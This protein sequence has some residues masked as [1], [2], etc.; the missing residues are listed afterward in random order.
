MKIILLRHEKRE[1]RRGFHSHLTRNGYD[2]SKLLPQKLEKYNIDYIFSSPFIRTLQTVYFVSKN[3]GIKVNPEYGLYEYLS[4]INF[5]VT[6]WYHELKEL[7]K[8]EFDSFLLDI[9]NKKYKSVCDKNDLSVLENHE[10]LEKRLSKFL[11]S[12]FNNKK[13]YNKTILIVSHQATLN[14]IS[15]I[16][17]KKTNLK[18]QREMGS[19]S[20]HTFPKKRISQLKKKLINITLIKKTKMNKIIKRKI[21]R[22]KRVKKSNT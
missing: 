7:K 21:L 2:D 3:L 18:H 16:L 13:Y 9:I 10:K 22:K 11:L 17:I 15:N 8:T 12:I 19:F 1:I 4:T 20:V 14:M 6:K 5:L